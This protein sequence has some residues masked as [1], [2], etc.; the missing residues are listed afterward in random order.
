[1]TEVRV[2]GGGALDAGSAV[3][4]RRVAVHTADRVPEGSRLTL[5]LSQSGL[6]SPLVAVLM[7]A[8]VRRFVGMEARG[9]AAT[10]VQT[11]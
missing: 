9:L 8:K 6:A 5:T 1:M 11:S 7:G 4:I 10:A 2:V 3:T